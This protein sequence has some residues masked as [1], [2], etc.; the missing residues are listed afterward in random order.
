MLWGTSY[1]IVYAN[2]QSPHYL[3]ELQWQIQPLWYAGLS[4]A[5]GPADPFRQR[6]FFTELNFK[7]GLPLTTGSMEDRDWFPIVDPPGS[8]THFSSHDNKT[9]LAL[10]AGLKGGF[11]FP[12]NEILCLKASLDISYMFFRFEARGGYIQY[13]QYSQNDNLN[14]PDNGNYNKGTS[15]PCVPWRADWYKG[16]MNGKMVSFDQHWFVA[17]PRGELVLKP[18]RFTIAA[19]LSISPFSFCYAVDNH[20]LRKTIFTEIMMMGLFVEPEVTGVF[21]LNENFSI[22]LNV[23]YRH[24]GEVRGN[25]QTKEQ[26]EKS[27][28]IDNIAGA[29]YRVFRGAALVRWM[30]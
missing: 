9:A 29:A 2:P 6:G 18:G 3:S 17:S 16:E 26:G 8:I 19:A 11:S 1:E 14:S 4:A 22:G 27:P 13:G 21:Q 12:L 10:L 15:N 20:I 23:S 24:I 5:F 25:T 7:A 28:W 30:P